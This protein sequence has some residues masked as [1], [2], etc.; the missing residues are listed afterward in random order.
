MAV[1]G[2]AR[3]AGGT[4]TPLHPGTGR[5]GGCRGAALPGSQLTVSPRVLAGCWWFRSQLGAVEGHITKGS[6]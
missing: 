6:H 5:E 2:L 4:R 1:P 3:R